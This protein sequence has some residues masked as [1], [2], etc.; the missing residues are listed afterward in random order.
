MARNRLSP[1][2]DRTILMADGPGPYAVWWM[3]NCLPDLANPPQGARPVRNTFQQSGDE[4]PVGIDAYVA[5]RAGW[6]APLHA[7][8]RNLHR[9]PQA[10]TPNHESIDTWKTSE[11]YEIAGVPV[12]VDSFQERLSS[13]SQL[14]QKLGDR[15]RRS[16]P[17]CDRPGAS[18]SH[19]VVWLEPSWKEPI[20]DMHAWLDSCRAVVDGYISE[21]MDP[22]DL[23]WESVSSWLSVIHT[24]WATFAT[25]TKER[26]KYNVIEAR[27]RH[28]LVDPIVLATAQQAQINAFVDRVAGLHGGLISACEQDSATKI[29]DDFY[30]WRSANWWPQ[31]AKATIPNRVWRGVVEANNTVGQ[32]TSLSQEMA[33]YAAV[34]DV[35][36]NQRV[37][38]HNQRLSWGGLLFALLAIV[39]PI[40]Q[41]LAGIGWTVVA[42]GAVLAVVGG[43]Y[44]GWTYRRKEQRRDK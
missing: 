38:R 4:Q 36:H 31:P 22:Q 32:V 25:L 16:A 7:G 13:P 18:T 44:A 14:T 27:V 24:P 3:V 12:V 21:R 20:A 35:R 43:M 11:F 41:S 39:L 8:F 33:D 23:E 40:V 10:S 37:E 9:L 30:R 42:G 26:H 28:L 29:R 5:E 17:S 34:E 15:I 2:V 6:V 19:V 1:D